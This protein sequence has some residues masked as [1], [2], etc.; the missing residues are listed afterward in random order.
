MK[1]KF[2]RDTKLT[3]EEF[4]SILWGFCGGVTASD[5]HTIFKNAE[6]PISRQ[7][8]ARKYT[9]LGYYLWDNVVRQSYIDMY[10]E[11]NSDQDRSS[12]GIENYVLD[13]LWKALEGT[14]NYSAFREVGSEYPGAD[15]LPAL[16]AR[17]VAFNGFSRDHFAGH[18]A[19][20]YLQA[21]QESHEIRYWWF[22]K[23]L[24]EKP[25]DSADI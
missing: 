4:L 1:N 5:M 8:I 14:L 16:K 20:A 12:F 15:I 24:L 2:L 23:Q 21:S 19:A 17:W 22:I 13:T 25:L 3:E 7:T 18:V 6:N 11:A 9:E 10:R